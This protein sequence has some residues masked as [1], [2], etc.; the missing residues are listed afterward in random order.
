MVKRYLERI[1]FCFQGEE[2]AGDFMERAR[3]G[4]YEY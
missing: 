2:V 3:Y 1:I 4:V